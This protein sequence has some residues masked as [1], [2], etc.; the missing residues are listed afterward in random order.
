MAAITAILED[1]RGEQAPPERY[2]L[3]KHRDSATAD[4]ADGEGS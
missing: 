2:D 1:I 4:S 3:R